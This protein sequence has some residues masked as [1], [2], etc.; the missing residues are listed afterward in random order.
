MRQPNR[1]LSPW[2][3]IGVPYLHLGFG[4]TH[5][6][7]AIKQSYGECQ[8]NRPSTIYYDRLACMRDL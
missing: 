4:K 7:G 6:G 8:A 5:L 2:L 1:D 3:G